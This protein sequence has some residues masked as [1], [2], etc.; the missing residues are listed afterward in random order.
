LLLAAVP[1]LSAGQA[2]APVRRPEIRVGDSWTYRSTNLLAPGPVE[3]EDRVSFV[4]D[5]VILL[6]ATS[7]DGSIERDSSWTPEWNAVTSQAGLIFRPDSGV[8]HFPLRVGEKHE[9]KYELL[10]PRMEL[11]DSATTGSVTVAG[12]E[13]V[14]VPAGKFRALRVELDSL[15]Q[16]SG[17]ARAFRR[18]ATLWYVPEVRRW[19]KLQVETPRVTINEELLRYKLNED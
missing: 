9:V 3:H 19:V 6:V 12:W 18:Q 2:D 8:F 16:P 4:S 14:D 10:R 5:K 13:S 11:P 1:L 15:V 7:K 17:G